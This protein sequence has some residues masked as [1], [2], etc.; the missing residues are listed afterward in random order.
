MQEGR[1]RKNSMYDINPTAWTAW[2]EHPDCVGVPQTAFPR[3]HWGKQM[4]HL[5]VAGTLWNRM[6]VA[7]KDQ[8]AKLNS[9]N[10]LNLCPFSIYSILKCVVVTEWPDYSKS[11]YNVK[12]QVAS[13]VIHT[14]HSKVWERKDFLCFWKNHLQYAKQSYIF[15]IKK[16]SKT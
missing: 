6:H 15:L 16:L 14:N 2:N 4:E 7:L 1:E 13:C 11:I 9:V 12:F 5:M 3:E 10:K 8:W